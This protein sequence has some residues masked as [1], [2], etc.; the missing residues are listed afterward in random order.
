M[1]YGDCCSFLVG[2]LQFVALM[3]TL[4]NKNQYVVP[5]GVIDCIYG[6]RDVHRG[7]KVCKQQTGFGSCSSASIS[8]MRLFLFR[9]NAI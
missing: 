6:L 9:L 1:V 7:Q 3:N 4:Y 8:G 2:I 5:E